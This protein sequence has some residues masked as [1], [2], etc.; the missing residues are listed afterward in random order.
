LSNFVSDRWD[1]FPMEA[2]GSIDIVDWDL[3][4][5]DEVGDRGCYVYVVLLGS[6]PA[7]LDWLLQGGSA[8]YNM[9]LSTDLN[10][11]P[12]QNLAPLTVNFDCSSSKIV[13]GE[14]AG[15]DWDF[16]DDGVF[17]VTNDQDGLES[18][19]YTQPG[20]YRCVVVIKATD[21]HSEQA[22]EEF[23]VVNPANTAPVASITPDK[24]IGDAPLAVHLDASASTD[25]GSIVKFEW[26]FDSDGD[27]D[28]SG[29]TLDTTDF[30]F[31]RYGVNTVTLR[32]TDNDFASDEAMVDITCSTGWRQTV[33]SDTVQ[34]YRELSQ[35]VVG[36]GP[37]S[38]PSVL[39]QDG[40]NDDMFFAQAL[41]SDGSVWA[42]PVAP[43]DNT[44]SLGDQSDIVYNPTAGVPE[45]IYSEYKDADFKLYFS[46]AGNAQGSSWNAPVEI[47]TDGDLGAE[48]ALSLGAADVPLV[49][50][51]RQGS[52]SGAGVLSLVTAANTD[53]TAWGPVEVIQSVPASGFFSGIDVNFIDGTPL[54]SAGV[55][56]QS[57]TYAG[58]FRALDSNGES[59]GGFQT[60][61]PTQYG[62]TTIEVALDRPAMAIGS[63]VSNSALLF[64][65][66]ND[67]AGTD[68]PA[69][70]LELQPPGQGGTCSMAIVSGAP[71][72]CFKSVT[73]GALK[74]I[75]ALDSEG[76]A[77]D[78][79]QVIEASAQISD[80]T[81]LA[82]SNGHPVVVFCDNSGKLT[83]A[84]FQN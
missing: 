36:G 82:N 40:D 69:Q 12:A 76:A 21:G 80:Y 83:C 37:A 62:R 13:G 31:A 18:Y 32:V 20:E 4:A 8:S 44:G 26:D 16:D 77:W 5:K 45:L 60:L 38:R 23:V 25:D 43:V 57:G 67:S 51:V 63:Q 17:E 65:R 41:T 61:V 46:R 34:I 52:L 42:A 10:S 9:N 14:F 33:I 84:W 70:P 79:P 47:E 6:S 1:W 50:C 78:T 66:A 22:Y 2:D 55:S 68:W 11:D 15:F 53:G 3:Y 64:I 35:C 49:A 59:W 24:T 19:T 74:F 71:A 28:L 81:S 58:C 56:D 54:V 29:P 30:N 72:V 73:G 75:R 48:C 39:Y 7:E 27:Y